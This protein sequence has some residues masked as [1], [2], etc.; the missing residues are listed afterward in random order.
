MKRFR[1][2]VRVSDQQLEAWGAKNTGEDAVTA[3][4][5][6]LGVAVEQMEGLDWWPDPAGEVQQS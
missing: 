4:V 2:T 5:T 6:G 3:A 1:L